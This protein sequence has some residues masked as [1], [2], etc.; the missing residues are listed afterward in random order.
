MAGIVM[1]CSVGYGAT[2]AAVPALAL[3]A[4]RELI[5]MW[6]GARGAEITMAPPRWIGYDNAI[7]LLQ[8][9]GKL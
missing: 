2:G 9:R 8:I 3:H 4:M 5:R 7:R 6:Y 1:R